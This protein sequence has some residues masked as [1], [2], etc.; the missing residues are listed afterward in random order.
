MS[1]QAVDLSVLAARAAP[2]AVA[3][4]RTILEQNV[5]DGEWAAQIGAALH[6]ADVAR[7]LGKS[8]QA[9]S[10]DQRLLR[11]RNRDGRPVYP[12][13]QFDGRQQLFGIAEVV[14]VLGPVLDALTVASWLTSPARALGHRRP[15]ELLR[16]GDAAAVLPLARRLAASAAA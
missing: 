2:E 10:K 5:S 14:A 11:I 4:A 12:A 3:L 15:V 13:V 9:V 7:L 6:Q 8:E 16:A 1:E